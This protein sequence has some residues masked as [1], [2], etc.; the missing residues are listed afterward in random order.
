MARTP[1]APRWRSGYFGERRNGEETVAP[2]L[3]LGRISFRQEGDAYHW[4]VGVGLLEVGLR[5]SALDRIAHD[6][7][8]VTKRLGK[9]EEVG[10]LLL[11][12]SSDATDHKIIKIEKVDTY[13]SSSLHQ[14]LG[15]RKERRSALE[16]DAVETPAAS[17]GA[18]VVGYYRVESERGS[19]AERDFILMRERFAD[20]AMICLVIRRS[21]NVMVSAAL[22][23]W[24]GKH[25]ESTDMEFPAPKDQGMLAH[26][27]P[28]EL[29][30]RTPARNFN[31]NLR[32]A[33]A[34]S[35]AVVIFAI[36]GWGL[37]QNRGA[38]NALPP[39]TVGLDLSAMQQGNAVQLVWNS[40]SPDVARAAEGR[41]SIMDGKLET[42]THLKAAELGEGM[43][44]YFPSSGSVRFRLDVL[45]TDGKWVSEAVA[46]ILPKASP[47]PSQLPS[48]ALNPDLN[49][50]PNDHPPPALPAMPP[51]V[52]RA[53]RPELPR[54]SGSVAAA[55]S[56]AETP[57]TTPRSQPAPLATPPSALAPAPPAKVSIDRPPQGKVDLPDTPPVSPP[58]RP[59]EVSPPVAA[60][61]PAI[62]P[63]PPAPEPAKSLPVDRPDKP[64]SIDKP[65]SED[66]PVSIDTPRPAEKA[67]P[68]AEITPPVPI[69]LPQPILSPSLKGMVTREI[70][71]Q[72]KLRINAAGRVVSAEPVGGQGAL[73][74]SLGKIAA[75]TA[76]LWKFQPARQNGQPVPSVVD[77]QFKFGPGR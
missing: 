66:K 57:A 63:L 53:A 49:T 48:G 25:L 17:S 29:I 30:A 77:I 40:Q 35:I 56:R 36:L 9:E 73:A 11:G 1:A 64:V 70:Q 27:A 6:L 13:C 44:R 15:V 47:S 69:Q 52:S 12:R 18:G 41:L 46:I 62:S 24:R 10:G 50:K 60:S 26:A 65:V 55:P 4:T 54:A 5:Q 71:I 34:I 19:L 22:C 42:Y 3:S 58:A 8:S 45:R 16:N 32:Y 33:A 20:P 7:E 68:A 39:K 2:K 51:V 28:R 23:F 75:E 59:P 61:Q 31:F 21:G 38:G 74:V 14:V 43:F 67:A 37:L 72:V 76:R